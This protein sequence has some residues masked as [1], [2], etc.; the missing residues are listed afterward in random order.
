MK[1]TVDMRKII[2]E[3]VKNET[4]YFKD[5]D[6]LA[7]IEIGDGN[8]NYI[9]RLY[10]EDQSM[11]IKFSDDHVRSNANRKL[12]SSRN[13]I[14]YNILKKQGELSGGLVPKLYGFSEEKKL[15]AMED[16]TGYKVLRIALEKKMIF[17]SFGNSMAKF[18]YDT[19]F[20]TTDLVS[21]SKTKKNAVSE[22]V[23]YDMC[24]ISERLV[25]TEPYLNQQGLNSFAEENR[26]YVEENIYNN[27]KLHSEVA[28]LKLNFMTSSES[29]IHGDLHSGSIFINDEGIKVFDPEFAFYGPMGY[30]IGNIVASLLITAMIDDFENHN[31]VSDFSKWLKK[32]VIEIIEGFI[33][34]YNEDYEKNV[35]T[36]MFNNDE[37]K[38]FYLSKILCETAGYAG[39]E[40]LRRTIGVAKV[41]DIDRV[42]KEPN[43]NVIE[44][45][46]IDIALEL[47]TNRNN[48]T[49]LEDY[50]K[51]IINEVK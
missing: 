35:M 16:L 26:R 34:I 9:Y 22:L 11:I 45:R 40:I 38:S 32:S 51:L 24:E 41:L 3:F 25:F 8:V 20:K 36:P 27:K 43:Y 47:I 13:K 44:K 5:T 30:D 37:F 48:L 17:P 4:N 21:D 28:K 31:K 2:L 14:E 39:T 50:R 46:L 18:L 33:N 7:M 10:N 23:N 6:N 15:I 29:M 49:S 19:L 1:S 42:K 12:S